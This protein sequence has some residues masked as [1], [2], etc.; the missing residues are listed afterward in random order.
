MKTVLRRSN[1]TAGGNGTG[2]MRGWALGLGV[3]ALVAVGLTGLAWHK[4]AVQPVHE[5]SVALPTIEV[6]ASAQ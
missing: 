1:R 4:G 6:G 5:M 3:A 2:A